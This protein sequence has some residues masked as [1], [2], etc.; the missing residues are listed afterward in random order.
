MVSV[1]QQYLGQARAM[2][3]EALTLDP[4]NVSALK[5]LM[6]S[7]SEELDV[8]GA[9]PSPSA[10]SSLRETSLKLSNLDPSN[11]DAQAN[12]QS[13]TIRQYMSGI[14]TP[15]RS[16]DESIDSLV[17]LMKKHPAD[18]DLLYY[19][20]IGKLRR[21]GDQVHSGNQDR[22]DQLNAEVVAMVDNALKSQP[23]N[24]SMQLRAAQI[25]SGLASA[26]PGDSAKY[27][28]AA[29]AAAE[30]ASALAHPADANFPQIEYAAYVAAMQSKDSKR[31]EQILRDFYRQSPD[32][33]QAALQLGE[34]LG[35]Q[36]AKRDEAIQILSKPF[37]AIGKD[38]IKALT[39]RQYEGERLYRV[40][41]LRADS[42]ASTADPAR[43][44]L[45]MDSLQE[46]LK[47]LNEI[48][49]G[50]TIAQ[51]RL[52]ARIH[53]LKAENIEAMASYQRALNLMERNGSKGP[54]EYETMYDA[55]RLDMQMGQT[56]SA[57]TLLNQIV[58]YNPAFLP[59]RAYLAELY[60]RQGDAD[61]AQRQIDALDK[62]TPD[63]PEVLRLRISQL[64]QQ[65]NPDAAKQVFNK[66]PESTPD[67]R[68]AKAQIALQSKDYPNAIRLLEV[69]RKQSADNVPAM[70]ALRRPMQSATRRIRRVPSWPIR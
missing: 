35:N 64:N 58:N 18:A 45:L 29:S 57:L 67:Q 33:P 11:L 51:L 31:A 34:F 70:L 63:S 61:A 21:A 43:Q 13:V 46:G 50:E 15:T 16:V 32:E 19:A 22:A 68:L 44:K 52:K 2:W 60:L 37:S 8:S 42:Y 48:S 66:L 55:A 30:R 1:D 36:P 28:A 40:S 56:G 47:K 6:Q 3:Q 17:N 24:A 4:R 5:H 10:F 53:Q 54:A 41:M 14:A 9:H 59:A 23:D 49:S 27:Q 39:S 20:A 26:V 62:M 12:V 25:Y 38:G 7:Y 69:V 65:K